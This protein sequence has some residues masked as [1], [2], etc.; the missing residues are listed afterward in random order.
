MDTRKLG[1]LAPWTERSRCVKALSEERDLTCR[2]ALEIERQRTISAIGDLRRG[3]RT[4]TLGEQAWRRREERRVLVE[5]TVT[6][7]IKPTTE[8]V[9]RKRDPF[10][11]ASLNTLFA[12]RGLAL[13]AA[14]PNPARLYGTIVFIHWAITVLIHAVTAQ[15]E[16]LCRPRATSA[17]LTRDAAGGGALC[18]ATSEPAA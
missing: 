16:L 10:N 13:E 17:L 7:I 12:E 11:A 6:V 1:E 18:R 8:P 15:I 2:R 5:A 4:L 9:G 3:G 14:A